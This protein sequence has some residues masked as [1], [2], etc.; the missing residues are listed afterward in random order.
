MARK[1]NELL[2][3]EREREAPKLVLLNNF[4]FLLARTRREVVKVTCW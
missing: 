1:V 3:R 2:K 4:F